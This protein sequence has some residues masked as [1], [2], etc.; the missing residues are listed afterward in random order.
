MFH[1]LKVRR[2]LSQ[3][4]L[5]KKHLSSLTDFTDFFFLMKT[6]IFLLLT[7]LHR[8]G[9]PGGSD[10]KETACNAGDMDSIPGSERS[11]GEG[12]ALHSSI[13]AWR[14]PWTE[15]SGE[16]QSVGLQ[17]VGHTEELILKCLSGAEQPLCHVGLIYMFGYGSH[18]SEPPALMTV[19]RTGPLPHTGMSCLREHGPLASDWNLCLLLLPCKDMLTGQSPA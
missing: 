9:F 6:W 8:L 14:I 4:S 16:L 3:E 2:N 15:Q 17:R 5:I 10:G 19:L 13:I 7:P 12:M 18:I 11:P 1:E